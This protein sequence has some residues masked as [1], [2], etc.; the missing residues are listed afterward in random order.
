MIGGFI[1]KGPDSDKVVVRAIG[2][3]LASPPF[4]LTNVL[5]NPTLSLFDVNGMVFA[6][7][8]DWRGT[9]EA[10]I[11]ATGLQPTNDA[12]SAIV[13]TLVPGNY[14]AIVRGVGGTTGVALVEVYGLN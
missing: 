9:Q 11:I 14:T 2:P 8:D 5:Q 7:N 1:I 3:S 4:S 6:S 12:E 10:D 13:T